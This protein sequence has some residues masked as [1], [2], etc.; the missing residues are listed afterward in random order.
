[1]RT[2]DWLADKLSGV[3]GTYFADISVNNRLFTRFGR[4]SRTRLG[5][6][7]AKPDPNF[8]LPVTYITI[9]G[10]FRDE[11]VPDYV[12]EATLAHEL[13]HYAHGFHSPLPK[14][15]SHPHRGN[16]VGKELLAR[17]A[18][19][20]VEQQEVWLKAEYASLLR[21]YQHA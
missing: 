11:S 12:I 1:M 6:I 21:N 19:H 17:G 9:T 5:S 2:N 18:Y 16:I 20:L 14:R 13:A 7:I 8:T 3:H 10:F 4:L 15:Y